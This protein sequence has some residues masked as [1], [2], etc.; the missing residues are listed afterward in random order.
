MPTGTIIGFPKKIPSPIDQSCVGYWKF[1]EVSGNIKDWSGNGNTGTAY[2]L[3]Y[4]QAGKFGNSCSF[5]GTTSYVDCG[6][7]ASLNITD[8]VTTEAWVNPNSTSGERFIVNKHDQKY[9]LEVNNNYFRSIIYDGSFTYLSS[10]ST[11]QIGNWYHIAMTYD[12]IKERLY[13]NGLLD[14]SMSLTSAIQTG[15]TLW[16]GKHISVYY[17]SGKIDDVRIYNRALSA[18][19]IKRHYMIGR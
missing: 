12:R 14:N 1:D 8:T 13:V 4:S 6:S 10:I 5:N 11:F 19:E 2:N 3:T 9:A 17:F 18:Q 15:T 7:G 16:I